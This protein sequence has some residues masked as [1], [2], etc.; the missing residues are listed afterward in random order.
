MPFNTTKMSSLGG[1]DISIIAYDELE[2]NKHYLLLSCLR[3]GIVQTNGLNA[4]FFISFRRFFFEVAIKHFVFNVTFKI[5][6][7]FVS[8]LASEGTY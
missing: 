4:A 7:A 2:I 3:F 8:W 5:Y 6:L 1:F